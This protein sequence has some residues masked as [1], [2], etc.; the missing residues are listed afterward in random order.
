MD[1]SQEATRVERI[2]T[3]VVCD[4]LVGKGNALTTLEWGT[5]SVRSACSYG[6]APEACGPHI[7]GHRRGSLAQSRRSARRC[8]QRC[9]QPIVVSSSAIQAPMDGGV[10]VRPC[11]S[12]CARAPAESSRENP[13]EALGGHSAFLRFSF[14]FR[15]TIPAPLR[16]RRV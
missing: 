14:T 9:G 11:S 1:R 13:L 6:H 12:H 3:A 16:R 2:C 8:L 4:E 10:T 15:E 5:H 7:C